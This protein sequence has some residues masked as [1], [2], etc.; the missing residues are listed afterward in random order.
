MIRELFVGFELW[1]H[2]AKKKALN[3]ESL[4]KN[5]YYSLGKIASNSIL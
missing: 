5:K 3:N 1:A 4:Y 2:D